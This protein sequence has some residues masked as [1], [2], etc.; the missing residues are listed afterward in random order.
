MEDGELKYWVAFTRIPHV[1]PARFR[2]LEQRFGTLERAWG[3]GLTEL[4]GE[5]LDSRAARSVAT[6]K[7]AIDPDDELPRLAD[8]GARA[9]S[10]GTMRSTRRA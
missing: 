10:P 2:L 9:R 7:L 3:A 6:S 4:R 8:S 1:G 5:G